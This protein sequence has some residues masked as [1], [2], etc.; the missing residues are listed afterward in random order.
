VVRTFL[1]LTND[2]TPEGRKLAAITNLHLLDKQFLGIDEINAFLQYNIAGDAILRKLF[3]DAGCGS[4]LH[5]VDEY[6]KERGQ[7]LSS[8]DFI[9]K[10]LGSIAGKQNTRSFVSPK[11]G[12]H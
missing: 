2:G 12:G 11:K 3:V 4:L 5:Y 9:H 6:F 7:P 1:F 8:A 10:Y